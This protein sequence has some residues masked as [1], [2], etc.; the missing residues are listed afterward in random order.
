MNETGEIREDIKQPEG[1]LG[2]EIKS[3]FEKDG[4][5]DQFMVT[6]LKAMGEEHAIAIKTMPK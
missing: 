2:K 6:I 4:K 1:D 5:D 3:K